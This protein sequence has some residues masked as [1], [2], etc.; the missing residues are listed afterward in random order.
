VCNFELFLSVERLTIVVQNHRHREE[1]R[2]SSAAHLEGK[3]LTFILAGGEGERLYPLTSDQ[4][5]PV[6]PFGG[7]FRIIDFTLS[8]VLNSGLRRIYVLTQYKHERL[9]SYVRGG[10][11]QLCNEFQRDCGEDM[12]CLP[13]SGGKRY[14]GTADA[15]FQ[16]LELIEK[17]RAEYVLIVSGDQV[18]HMNYGELLGR[19][20]TSGADL[21]M[22]AVEY[23]VELAGSLD[24]IEADPSGRIIGFEE[25]PVSPRPLQSNPQK[26]L[27]NMGVYVFG[28][29]SLIETLR[30]NAD[31]NGSDDFGR[32]IVPSLIRTG[33]A[34]VFNFGGYWRDVGTLDGYYQTNLDLLLTSAAFDPY[35][36]AAWP[37]RT[38]AG[39]KSLQ[40]SGLASE[41]RVSLNATLTSCEVWMS[42]VST[43]VRID[44]D[45]GLE[46][47]IVL[48]EAH[49]GSGAKIRNAI[50]TE[51]TV[52]PSHARIGYDTA[53]DRSQ[54]IV[55]K[56]GIV[57]VGASEPRIALETSRVPGTPFKRL[58]QSL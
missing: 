12:V 26:A 33:R 16:N 7:V 11:P 13:P 41:S 39:P 27:V 4:P 15:V 3:T 1:R 35:E 25:K 23:P 14:R 19:H 22:A 2:M 10:W 56:N 54:F 34:V 29:E 37:T 21:T 49:I 32:D 52:V 20:A 5:K 55:S 31:L 38:L 44:A 47:A 8:N 57:I 42:I 9:H 45:A 46:A 24:V 43:G 28:R 6:V 51:K 17:T 50:V 53:A 18:Y 36:N 48:P 30:Q 58:N 40:R